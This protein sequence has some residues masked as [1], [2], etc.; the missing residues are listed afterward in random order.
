MPIQYCYNQ[1]K[2]ESEQVAFQRKIQHSA[3]RKRRSDTRYD[4]DTQ[5]K[6]EDTSKAE[7]L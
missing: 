6:A 2:E 3:G 4:H 1:I 5:K 7:Q